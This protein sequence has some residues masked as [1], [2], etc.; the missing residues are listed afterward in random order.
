MLLRLCAT[1][2]RWAITLTYEIEASG[3]RQPGGFMVSGFVVFVVFCEF[4][5]LVVQ[6]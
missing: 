4:G 2:Q 6:V 3:S 1:V 5:M